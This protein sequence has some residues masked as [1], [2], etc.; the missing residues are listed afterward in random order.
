MASLDGGSD[1]ESVPETFEG[2]DKFEVD[3]GSNSGEPR[4][5]MLG[6][7]EQDKWHRRPWISVGHWMNSSPHRLG[8]RCSY[9]QSAL[10]RRSCCPHLN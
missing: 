4:P 1:E 5:G 3:M 8:R 6:M 2:G 9:S 7:G 10:T